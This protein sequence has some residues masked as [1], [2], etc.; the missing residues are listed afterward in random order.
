MPSGTNKRLQR[1]HRGRGIYEWHKP[2][3]VQCGY[4]YK[5]FKPN[6]Q[7]DR[8][9]IGVVPKPLFNVNEIIEIISKTNNILNPT[10]PSGILKC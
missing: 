9:Q 3:D 5:N 2:I 1:G 4:V 6:R 10:Y 7:I 8:V